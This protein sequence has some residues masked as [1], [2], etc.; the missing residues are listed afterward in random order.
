[1]TMQNSLIKSARFKA[2]KLV[3]EVSCGSCENRFYAKQT[4]VAGI[5]P[6]I[7]KCPQC[8]A[9]IEFSPVETMQAISTSL[10]DLPNFTADKIDKAANEM[11]RSWRQ[12]DLI[13]GL[14][15]YKGVNLG[16]V[17]DNQLRDLIARS[18]YTETR[19]NG[20]AR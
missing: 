1:M 20:A 3:V 7:H 8:R 6:A 16:A 5:S 11:T 2:G 19:K 10:P 4:F 13:A 12:T 14:L 15:Y 17:C 18:L 9:F